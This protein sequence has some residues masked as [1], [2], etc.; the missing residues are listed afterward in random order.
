MESKG[1]R[2]LHEAGNQVAKA[3]GWPNDETMQAALWFCGIPGIYQE[4]LSKQPAPFSG[5]QDDIDR[6]ESEYEE[7]VIMLEEL[8]NT[9]GFKPIPAHTSEVDWEEVADY[10]LALSETK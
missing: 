4:Q 1:S 7:W 8:A 3:H 6:W 9:G 10:L 2:Y 5:S